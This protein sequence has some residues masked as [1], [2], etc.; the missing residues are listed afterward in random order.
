[1]W[2]EKNESEEL[3]SYNDDEEGINQV[4]AVCRFQIMD[5]EAQLF[6]RNKEK[7]EFRLKRDIPHDIETS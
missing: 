7:T 1:N 2:V 3:E 5:N 4:T 6:G